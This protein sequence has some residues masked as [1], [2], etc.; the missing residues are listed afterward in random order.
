MSCQIYRKKML[1]AVSPIS[2][3]PWT[4]MTKVPSLSYFEAQIES[5]YILSR[6]RAGWSLQL[7]ARSSPAVSKL[8]HG[9]RLRGHWLQEA[10]LTGHHVLTQTLEL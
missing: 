8:D 9:H 6:E 3:V 4:E 2:T 7:C 10:A 1:L 5:A